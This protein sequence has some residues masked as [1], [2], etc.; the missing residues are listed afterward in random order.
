M[1][2]DL[3]KK[4]QELI[5]MAQS[6]GVEQNYFFTTTF[7]RYVTQLSIL[8]KLKKTITE[9]ETLV[10]KEYV[11]GR[12][13]VVIHPAITEYNKTATAANQTATTLLKIIVTLSEHTLQD[14]SIKDVEL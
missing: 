11:K 13:N 8:M 14:G 7:D 12:K 5:E 2:V 3:N 9:S 6:G 10:E 1:K 4:A